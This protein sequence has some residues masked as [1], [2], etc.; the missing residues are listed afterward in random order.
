MLKAVTKPLEACIDGD[1]QL[2]EIRH[3]DIVRLETGIGQAGE[4]HDTSEE[5]Q[6]HLQ[7]MGAGMGGY[8]SSHW[9]APW[10]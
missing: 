7:C 10:P 9:E 3:K 2:I 5:D 8:T 6:D 4:D 1:A